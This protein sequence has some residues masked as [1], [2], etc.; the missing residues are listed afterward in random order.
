MRT[1]VVYDTRRRTFARIARRIASAAGRIRGFA[2]RLRN[3]RSA[4]RL[5]GEALLHGYG[6]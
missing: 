2:G 1:L 6:R 5:A 3:L 4:D